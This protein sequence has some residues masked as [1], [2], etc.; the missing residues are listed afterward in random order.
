[1]MVCICNAIR[2]TQV[3]E[4]ARKAE[5]ARHADFLNGEMTS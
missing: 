3:R 1:M 5:Y 2:E 4:A